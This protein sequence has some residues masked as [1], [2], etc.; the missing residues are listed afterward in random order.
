MVNFSWNSKEIDFTL[1]INGRNDTNPIKQMI[2]RNI[3]ELV[4]L[5]IGLRGIRKRLVE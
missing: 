5:F 4:F 2:N 3:P 1:F